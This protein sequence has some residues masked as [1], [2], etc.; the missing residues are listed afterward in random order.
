MSRPHLFPVVGVFTKLL[1]R[2][3][4]VFGDDRL[5]ICS[6][7]P[8]PQLVDGLVQLALLIP[9]GVKTVPMF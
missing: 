6:Q 7:Q 2:A 4:D 8:H 1:S 9:T 3:H 5:S